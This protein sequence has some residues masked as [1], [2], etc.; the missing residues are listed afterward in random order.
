VTASA[1]AG[2]VPFSAGLEVLQGVGTV[3]GVTVLVLLAVVADDWWRS[4]LDV[5]A[6]R[7]T[8]PA[9]ARSSRRQLRRMPLETL[10]KEWR[11]VQHGALGPPEARHL[12]AAA[13]V[14]ALVRDELER[15]DPLGFGCWMADGAVGPPEQHL[16]RGPGPSTG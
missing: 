16:G 9:A 1:A 13:Q 10:F 5:T 3:I 15:R 4:S 2:V 11:A 8:E 12:L 7:G 6:V 14:R